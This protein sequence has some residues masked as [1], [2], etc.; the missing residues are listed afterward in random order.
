[1]AL[2]CWAV[3]IIAY[4]IWHKSQVKDGGEVEQLTMDDFGSAPDSI[5][6]ADNPNVLDPVHELMR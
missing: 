4:F 3:A 2:V 6:L 5:N 1:M